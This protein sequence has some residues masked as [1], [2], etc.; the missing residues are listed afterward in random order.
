MAVAVNVTGDPASPLTRAVAVLLFVPAIVPRVQV[1]DAW[2]VEPVVTVAVDSV[3]PPTVVAHE[4]VTPGTPAPAEVVTR[5]TSGCASDW[6]TVPVW[7][8]PDIRAIADGI[9]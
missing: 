2:P 8:L 7:A 9:G 6:P 3:P 1:T 5:T 4:T